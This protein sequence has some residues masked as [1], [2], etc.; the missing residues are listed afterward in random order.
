MKDGRDG[1]SRNFK[2]ENVLFE[3]SNSSILENI[4]WMRKFNFL[5]IITPRKHIFHRN[6]YIVNGSCHDVNVT[7][8]ASDILDHLCCI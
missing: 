8:L 6:N 2:G 5:F 7:E 4:Q 1:V 3:E